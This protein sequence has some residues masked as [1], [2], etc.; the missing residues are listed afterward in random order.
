MRGHGQKLTHKQE[1]LIAALLTEST[2]P[3]DAAKAG[4]SE[5]TLHRGRTY[6]IFK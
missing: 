6:P 2:H 4:V 5:A 1:A 3:A